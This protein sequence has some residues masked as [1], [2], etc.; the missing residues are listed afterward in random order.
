MEKLGCLQPNLLSAQLGGRYQKI[1]ACPL[2]LGTLLESSLLGF[3]NVMQVGKDHTFI[4][5]L[6][7]CKQNA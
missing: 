5:E 4:G 3:L 6:L 1:H 2:G 7:R